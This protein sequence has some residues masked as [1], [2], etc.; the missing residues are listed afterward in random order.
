[1]IN[2]NQIYQ[3]IRLNIIN[4]RK[5]KHITKKEIS[6]IL[7]V[8]YNHYN[9]LEAGRRNFTIPQL[10]TLANYFKLPIEEFFRK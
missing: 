8:H 6:S 1:M 9:D 2:L 3:I 4:L 5:Q 7:K 10:D